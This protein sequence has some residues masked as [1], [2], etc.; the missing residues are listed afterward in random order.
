MARIEDAVASLDSLLT[1]YGVDV[2]LVDETDSATANFV[3][4]VAPATPNGG[5][6]EGI[7]GSALADGNV[8]IVQGWDWYAGAD[9]AAIG[10][11]QYDFQTV[12]T[13]ELGHVLGLGHSP[14]ASSV[15]YA[16]LDP[17]EARRT[18]TVA[19]LAIPNLEEQVYAHPLVA[20]PF[21][22]GHEAS[23]CCGDCVAAAIRI[24][25][26]LVAL[27]LALQRRLP[28]GAYLA[29]H[30]DFDHNHVHAL[31][32]GTALAAP[33][34][35]DGAWLLGGWRGPARSSSNTVFTGT[36]RNLRIVADAVGANVVPHDQL[37]SLLHDDVLPVSRAARQATALARM[38]LDNPGAELM[39]P[40]ESLPFI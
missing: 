3:L 27:E 1:D 20:A 7:L 29:E 37:G 25:E 35:G 23:C 22:R 14:D 16:A 30:G 39:D 19:D 33:H 31:A 24:P 38:I 13:H 32:A 4:A 6:A 28:W 2:T 11:G 9:P 5:A 21:K 40:L 17:Q 34:D 15:M 26:Q 18:M 36:T 8:I 10:A 12:V